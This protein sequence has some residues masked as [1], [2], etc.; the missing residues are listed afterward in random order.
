MNDFRTSIHQYEEF[1]KYL[2]LFRFCVYWQFQFDNI[3]N[4][5]KDFT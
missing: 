1:L 4:N 3:K 2:I 5:I